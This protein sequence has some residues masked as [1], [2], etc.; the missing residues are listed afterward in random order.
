VVKELKKLYPNH[1]V[2]GRL[3]S[4]WFS[5]N[6]VPNKK[7][8]DVLFIDELFELIGEPMTKEEYYDMTANFGSKLVSNRN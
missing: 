4:T 3:L 1:N 8:K 5:K 7:K 2:Y 6:D